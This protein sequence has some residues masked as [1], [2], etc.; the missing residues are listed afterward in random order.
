MFG[1][2][3][4]GIGARVPIAL[5][6]APTL[7]DRE[8]F[9]PIEPVDPIDPGQLALPPQQDEQPAIAEPAAF[10]GQLAQPGTQLN[11]RRPA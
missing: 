7:A 10:V 6:R 3:S 1:F 5:R 9:L 2:A 11:V 4:T 8:P